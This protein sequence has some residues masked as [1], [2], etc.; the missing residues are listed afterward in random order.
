[1][2]VH[3]LNEA[4]RGHLAWRLDAHTGCGMGVAGRI[5]RGEASDLQDMTLVE[6]FEWAGKT[7]RSALIHARRVV[8]F[9]LDNQKVK[10]SKI[11]MELLQEFFQKTKSMPR[12][13]RI[14]VAKHLRK[15]LQSWRNLMKVT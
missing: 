13:D 3:E 6:L 2:Y 9:K 11:S 7:H 12:E 4:Q 10:V 8:E 15:G 5:A 1:M 14:L